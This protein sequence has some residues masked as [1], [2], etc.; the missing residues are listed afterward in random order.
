[1]DGH[2]EKTYAAINGAWDAAGLAGRNVLTTPGA[3]EA[4]EAVAA[5][6]VSVGWPE[7]LSPMGPGSQDTWL[8]WLHILSHSVEESGHGLAHA[9]L[10]RALQR[11]ALEALQSHR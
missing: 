1:M 7:G 6:C 8:R 3:T 4:I 10:E 9:N 5:Y 2:A 11:V